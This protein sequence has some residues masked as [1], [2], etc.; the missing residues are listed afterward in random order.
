MGKIQMNSLFRL[1]QA[2]GEASKD[3]SFAVHRE[4]LRCPGISLHDRVENVLWAS[5]LVETG[6]A[7]E[8]QKAVMERMRLEW[9][10]DPDI[11][12]S[13]VMYFMLSCVKGILDPENQ[14]NKHVR[15]DSHMWTDEE[16]G[17]VTRRLAWFLDEKERLWINEYIAWK[18]GV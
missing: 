18:Q 3:N 7:Q 1:L 11:D 15:H 13:T 4:T 14:G 6:R 10:N 5:Q 9:G 2:F 8:S 12:V 16:E 17:E